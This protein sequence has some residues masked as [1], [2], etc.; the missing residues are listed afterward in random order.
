MASKNKSIS[1][2]I[3]LAASVIVVTIASFF[4][5]KNGDK[6]KSNAASSTASLK[7]KEFKQKPSQKFIINSERDTV[8]E[9]ET[10]TL[11]RIPSQAFLASNGQL[12]TGKVELQYREFH[13]VGEILMSG[14]PMEYDSAQKRQD[15]ES[16]GMFEISAFQNNQSLATNPSK[17][18]EVN[19]ASLDKSKTKFNQ[20]NFDSKTKKWKYIKKDIA[21]VFNKNKKLPKSAANGIVEPVKPKLAS[22]TRPR[23]KINI[24]AADFPELRGFNKLLF[25]VAPETKNYDESTSKI[26]WF[27]VDIKNENPDK[28]LYRITFSND[29]KECIVFANPVVEQKNFDEALKKYTLIYNDY[30]AKQKLM[31]EAQAANQNWLAREVSLNSSLQSKFEFMNDERSELTSKT[32]QTIDMV[33]RTFQVQN[34]GIWNSDCPSSMPKGIDLIAGFVNEDGTKASYTKII[35]IDK[36]RNALFNFYTNHISFNPQADNT[37]LLIGKDNSISCCKASEISRVGKK[38]NYHEF[39]VKSL[40]KESYTSGDING[41]V[42]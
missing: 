4:L 21:N 35:L 28:N 36:S 19:M 13:N 6:T 18:I 41:L 34:F 3:A 37:I 32:N 25:E 20:Y 1:K 31:M 30:K 39:K 5:L 8:I 29:N 40:K 24:N 33:Y 7:K 2:W 38:E 11:L 22:E 10:G 9:F 23:F 17:L 12:I 14:I 26:N 16:A 15:F 42:M 27:E